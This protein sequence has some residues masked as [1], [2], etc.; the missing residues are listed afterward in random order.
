MKVVLSR[1]SES[2]LFDI[3]F[4]IAKDSPRR[5]K[6]YARELRATC[7]SLA[8]HPDRFPVVVDAAEPL[9]RIVHGNYL[10]F[11]AVRSDHVRVSRIIHSAR[12]F[13]SSMF[14]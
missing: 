1:E 8:C 9:R 7:L 12:L 11:Y 4:E 13:D 5:A 14:R 6:S 10:I 2:D 3:A